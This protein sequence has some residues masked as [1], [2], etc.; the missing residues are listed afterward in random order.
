MGYAGQPSYIHQFRTCESFDEAGYIPMHQLILL[1]K[2]T[3]IEALECLY[4]GL[5]EVDISDLW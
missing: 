3:L 5:I 2:N 4:R 1:D